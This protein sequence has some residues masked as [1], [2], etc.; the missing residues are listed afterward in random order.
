MPYLALKL[1]TIPPAPLARQLAITLTE[2]TVTLLRKRR[3]LTAVT[4]ESLPRGQWFIGAAAVESQG[5]AAFHLE[6]VVTEGTNSDA[7]KADFVAASYAAL[8]SALGAVAL[9]S[10]VI[11]RDVDGRAWGYGGMSQA[12][13]KEVRPV[14]IV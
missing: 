10:Y 1:S 2:L 7:E 12:A 4:V 13:R 3:E 14:A 8:E 9:T 6:I 5:K 11:I